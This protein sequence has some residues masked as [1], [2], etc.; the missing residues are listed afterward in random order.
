MSA[1]LGHRGDGGCPGADD[2]FAFAVGRLAAGARE[3]IAGHIESCAAC[4]SH[5]NRLDD[6]NDALVA[7]L[8]QPVSTAPPVT[9]RRGAGLPGVAEPPPGAAGPPAVPGYEIIQE[10]G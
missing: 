9:G 3:Q 4:V 10:L 8:R 1:S 6:Q 2:L 7:E 5:L